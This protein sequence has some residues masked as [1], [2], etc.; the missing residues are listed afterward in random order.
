[1]LIFRD[2][3]ASSSVCGKFIV[4]PSDQFYGDRKGGVKDPAGNT[5]WIAIHKE[6]VSSD[7]LK[8]RAEQFMK[9]KLNAEPAAGT[10]ILT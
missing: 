6:D 4:C 1:M 3:I 5:W 10:K 8:K 9:N 7:E 2:S